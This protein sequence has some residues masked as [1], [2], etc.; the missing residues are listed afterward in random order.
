VLGFRGP[1][2]ATPASIDLLD[3][4]L[5]DSAHIQEKEAEWQLRHQHRR[6]GNGGAECSRRLYTVAQAQ[7]SLK[8]LRPVPYR[9]SIRPAESVTVRFHDAGHILGSAWLEVTVSGE[10]RPRRLVFSGDLGMPAG[11]VLHDPEKV[12]PE[13]DVL[14]IESTYGDR[15]HRPLAETEDE[16]VAAFER[17]R[18]ATAT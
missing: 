5:R 4:L 17:T 16:I 1:V 12:V 10:G 14:L 8:L 9:E 7:A 15:L 6:G 11:P 18:P 13:A 2:Y 3:V